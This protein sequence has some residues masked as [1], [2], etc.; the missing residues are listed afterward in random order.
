MKILGNTVGTAVIR[1]NYEQTDST[2]ADYLIGKDALDQNIEAAKNAAE[3]AQTAANNAQTAADEANNVAYAAQVKHIAVTAMLPASAWAENSQ[4]VA[5]EGV[6]SDNTVFIAPAADGYTD[7]YECGVFCS[8]QAQ[9]SL[10]FICTET[11]ISDLPVNVV[12]FN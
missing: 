6:T 7:Y 9:G 2:K 10:S 3:N 11:P 12:I 8:A 5:V 4:T 1:T